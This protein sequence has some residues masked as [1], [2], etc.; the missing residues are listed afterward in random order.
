MNQKKSNIKYTIFCGGIKE[1]GA[2]KSKKII[3]YMLTKYV[4]SILWGVAVRLS[5]I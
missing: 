5:Y 3:K 4:K 1:D 2:R